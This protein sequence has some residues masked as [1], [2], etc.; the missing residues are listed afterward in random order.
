MSASVLYLPNGDVKLRLIL[1][2]FILVY[3]KHDNLSIDQRWW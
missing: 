3:F 1:R 2:D